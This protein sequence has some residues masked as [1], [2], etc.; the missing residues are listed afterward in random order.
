LNAAFEQNTATASLGE[1]DRDEARRLKT[2][3]KLRRANAR[4]LTRTIQTTRA[5]GSHADVEVITEGDF[6]IRAQRCLAMKRAPRIHAANRKITDIEGRQSTEVRAPSAIKT[7]TDQKA[8][9]LL[10]AQ[11]VAALAELHKWAG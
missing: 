10:P 1:I 4:A 3:W 5:I 8:I 7:L 11:G 6:E 2:G 9:A